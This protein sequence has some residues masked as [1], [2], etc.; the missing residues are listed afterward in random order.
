MNLRLILGFIKHHIRCVILKKLSKISCICCRH[1]GFGD[2]ILQVIS[3]SYFTEFSYN[4]RLLHQR[5]EKVLLLD[6]AVNIAVKAWALF[7]VESN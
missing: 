3:N 7:E 5:E 6:T 2:R 4:A 1:K